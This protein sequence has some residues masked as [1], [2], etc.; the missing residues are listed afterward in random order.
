MF[1]EQCTHEVTTHCSDQIGVQVRKARPSD[2]PRLP[3]PLRFRFNAVSI[4]NA[5]KL[6]ACVCT[7]ELEPKLAV[8][9]YLLLQPS[10]CSLSAHYSPPFAI[11]IFRRGGR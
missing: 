11:R 6:C 9:F 1:A 3:A 8:A 5:S 7:L 4:R 2:Q 10:G